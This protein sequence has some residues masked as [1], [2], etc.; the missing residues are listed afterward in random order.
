MS[1]GQDEISR[2]TNSDTGEFDLDRARTYFDGVSPVNVNQISTVLT[3]AGNINMMTGSNKSWRDAW[4]EIN[5]FALPSSMLEQMPTVEAERFT[6]DQ[7]RFAAAMPHIL[8]GLGISHDATTT[9]E[10]LQQ[11][12]GVYVDYVNKEGQNDDFIS[13][14]SEGDN[15]TAAQLRDSQIKALRNIAGSFT[16]R[17][18]AITGGITPIQLG[19]L[20]V[21][22]RNMKDAAY[23]GSNA[24]MNAI[25]PALQFTGTGLLRCS[26]DRNLQ[27]TQNDPDAKMDVNLAKGVKLLTNIIN[28]PYNQS[29][30]VTFS[31]NVTGLTTIADIILSSG[32]DI[33]D[34]SLRDDTH[35]ELEL[36]GG[37]RDSRLIIHIQQKGKD[38]SIRLPYAGLMENATKLRALEDPINYEYTGFANQQTWQR[39]EDLKKKQ[40][41]INAR[42][43]GMRIGGY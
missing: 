18:A 38:V 40:S 16:T 12:L 34:S 21:A 28:D 20:P 27:W 37:P 6:L 8:D 9:Q 13:L 35:F 31:G 32:I 24:Q 10:T 15:T 7:R 22:G 1:I 11:V 3:L 30:G 36:Q 41:I 17:V 42:Y 19:S 43:T 4:G 25:L 14:V 33:S 5:K 26:G 23:Q 2:F 29:H 39:N